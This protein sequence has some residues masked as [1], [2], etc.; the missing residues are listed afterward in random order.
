[1][2]QRVPVNCTLCC[3]ALSRCSTGH[4]GITSPKIRSC[5]SGTIQ[6]H[7]RHS[8]LVPASWLSNR[9]PHILAGALR[10]GMEPDAPE[11]VWH[12]EGLWSTSTRAR[13]GHLWLQMRAQIAADAQLQPSHFGIPSQG[14]SLPPEPEAAPFSQHPFSLAVGFHLLSPGLLWCQPLGTAMAWQ[15]EPSPPREQESTRQPVLE[16]TSSCSTARYSRSTN[17]SATSC[18][19]DVCHGKSLLFTAF[20][21]ACRARCLRRGRIP[22]LTRLCSFSLALR[23][24]LPAGLE[25]WHR[26]LRAA[27]RREGCASARTAIAATACLPPGNSEPPGR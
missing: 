23:A 1:M 26:G 13:L 6:L 3:A 24:S 7:T 9:N 19:L 22:V 20:Q 11:Q 17:D 21:A 8:L 27:S 18:G 15:R 4:C 2:S 16:A 5:V 12:P 14:R 10:E 25:Q